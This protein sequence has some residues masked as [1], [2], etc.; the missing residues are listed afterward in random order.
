MA[1]RRRL[2]IMRRRSERGWPRSVR[3]RHDAWPRR[4]RLDPRRAVLEARVAV[5]AV[6]DVAAEEDGRRFGLER[7][8]VPDVVHGRPRVARAGDARRRRVDE[9]EERRV[10][11]VEDALR[12]A[13]AEGPGRDGADVHGRRVEPVL[14]VE[15]GVRPARLHVDRLQAQHAVAVRR[16]ARVPALDVLAAHLHRHGAQ[17][18]AAL[19][20]RDS[21]DAVLAVDVEGGL[22][23]VVEEPRLEADHDRGQRRSREHRAP[24]RSLGP[25]P[26]LVRRRRRRRQSVVLPRARLEVHVERLPE[27]PGAEPRPA[28]V[29]E[30]HEAR[31][32]EDANLAAD[33]A[34]RRVGRVLVA[35]REVELARLVVV[36]IHRR[37]HV[38]VDQL[39]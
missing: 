8:K 38:D 37:P 34:P 21:A 33:L 28:L 13:L 10:L 15:R 36:G 4:G 20:A 6:A 30:A 27:A 35:R 9:R 3:A 7:E 25:I 12:A 39:A 31:V 11:V 1:G 17:V 22:A 18:L 16:E 29:V 24:V 32:R 26:E 23:A 19:G 14:H 5:E 2:Q